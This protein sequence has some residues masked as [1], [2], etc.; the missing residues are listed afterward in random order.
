VVG[1]I[2][3]WENQILL[4]RRAIE[5]RH[6]YWTLPAGFLEIGEST[7]HG[8]IRETMEEAGADVEIQSL[9]SLLNV[10]HVEQVH[11][12]YLAQMRTP[13]FAAGTESLEVALFTEETIPWTELAFPTVKQ[14]LQW[15]FADARAGHLGDLGVR[16]RDILP[17]ERIG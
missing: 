3:I 1:T 9:Y 16:T 2:P 14:T 7:E 12:F 17:G 8:A 11:L 13:Q 10:A 5:P 6:G 15:Y 4:C